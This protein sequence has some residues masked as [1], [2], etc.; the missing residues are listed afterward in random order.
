M[1]Y[2]FAPFPLPSSTSINFFLTSSA[3][4]LSLTVV[5]KTDTSSL[6]YLHPYSPCRALQVRQ[7]RDSLSTAQQRATAAEARVE[8]LQEAVRKA[9]ERAARL[10]MERNSRAAAG[11]G[12]GQGGGGTAAG[13]GGGTA[14]TAGSREAE[15]AAEVKLLREELAAAQVGDCLA[16]WLIG[17]IS[18]LLA[19]WVSGVGPFGRMA[20]KL[21]ATN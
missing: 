15:L 2:Y 14:A 21:P 7:L 6:T 19:G 10:E 3:T 5:T 17:W 1:A 20:L 12:E 16:G 8:L 11:G 4:F 18:G 9:E 13:A